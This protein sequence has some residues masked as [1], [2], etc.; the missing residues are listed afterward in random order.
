M[1]DNEQN[2]NSEPKALDI[3][4]AAE[5]ILGRWDDGETLSEVDEDATSEDLEETEVTLSLIHI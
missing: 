2:V 3:D 4:D 5:A 1:N